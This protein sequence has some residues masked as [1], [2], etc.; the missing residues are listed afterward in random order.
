MTGWA[1]APGRRGRGAPKG[2]V[3]AAVRD[4]ELKMCTW[5][6]ERGCK[7]GLGRAGWPGP[8]GRHGR[9][10]AHGPGPQLGRLI[11]TLPEKERM[12]WRR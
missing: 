4:K 11:G 3:A 8:A 12:M 2:I 7:A 1:G 6:N 9:A 5:D 10:K